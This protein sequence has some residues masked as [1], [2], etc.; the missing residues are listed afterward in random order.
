MPEAA[1][2]L[3]RK[4]GAPRPAAPQGLPEAEMGQRES[5]QDNN[6]QG[7]E[8]STQVQIQEVI[9]TL[10]EKKKIRYLAPWAGPETWAHGFPRG[11]QA[12]EPDQLHLPDV[13]QLQ[14]K[15]AGAS[16]PVPCGH[17]RWF[18]TP[19]KDRAPKRSCSGKHTS[20]EAACTPR[21]QG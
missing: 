12:A 13:L 20:L 3:T 18:P 14:A 11:G 1:P 10:K 6:H 19:C 9:L 7:S 16:F 2:L 15:D 17:Q 8:H 5:S 4:G 21:T